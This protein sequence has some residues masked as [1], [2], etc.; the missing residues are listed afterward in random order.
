L[1]TIQHY[2][3]FWSVFI[4]TGILVFITFD[5]S[6]HFGLGSVRLG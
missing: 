3:L 2:W 5:F 6:G 4:T 1:V